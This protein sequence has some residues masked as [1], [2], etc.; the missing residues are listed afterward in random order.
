LPRLYKAANAPPRDRDF[1]ATGHGWRKKSV[2]KPTSGTAGVLG[3]QAPTQ[4]AVGNMIP[5]TV[6]PFP[7]GATLMRRTCMCLQGQESQWSR[8]M[9][10]CYPHVRFMF[11]LWSTVATQG[12][13]DVATPASAP[14]HVDISSPTATALADRRV[15]IQTVVKVSRSVAATT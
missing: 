14:P 3:L 11:V 13:L 6:A 5:H 8:S 10:I 12:L 7:H 15:R 1:V 2:T 9:F 4:P